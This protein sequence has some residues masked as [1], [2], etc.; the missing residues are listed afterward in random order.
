[1]DLRSFAKNTYDDD[2][3]AL[4][5]PSANDPHL[6]HA[7]L[8]RIT[9]GD[10]TAPNVYHQKI[11]RF[12]AGA[13]ENQKRA[14]GKVKLWRLPPD[15]FAPAF[16]V[17]SRM[18]AVTVY[19]FHEK[20]VYIGKELTGMRL[21]PW[22]GFLANVLGTVAGTQATIAQVEQFMPEGRFKALPRVYRQYRIGSTTSIWITS[23]PSM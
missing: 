8:A 20:E 3:Q 12:S 18:G 6:I 14:Q 15:K 7:W 1:M 2:A 22:M 17:V 21:P 23:T 11:L 13:G 10:E 9:K 4:T 19:P 5:V 16:V